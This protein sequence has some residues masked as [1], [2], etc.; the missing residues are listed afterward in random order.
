MLATLRQRDFALLWLAGLISVAGDFALIVALPLHV[1]QM[2]GS[3]IATAGTL[4][5]SMLPHVL[6]G[7]VAGVFV[8]RWDRKRT[9]VVVDVARA[10][11]LLPLLL[12]PERLEMVYAI[13]AVQGTI[14]LFFRPAEGALLPRLVGEERLV[15]ANA[16]NALNDNL[17][18]L[19]G[20][21]LGALLYARAGIGGVVL[22][23]AATYV[24]SALLIGLI[25]GNAR[26]EPVTDAIDGISPWRRV[27]G[28]WRS[29]LGIVGRNQALRV[30]FAAAAMAGVA[31]GVFLTL[32]LS[33]LVLDV[34]GGTPAQVGW[35]GSA[36]AVGGLI[37]GVVVA[38]FGGRLATRWL[39]GGGMVGIGLADLGTANARLFAGPGLPAVSVAMGWSTLAGLPVVAA[40][41]GRQ[42]LVQTQAADAYR[43]RVFGALGAIQGGAM[44]LGFAV[45]GVLGGAWG[46]VPTLSA[47]AMVRVLGGLLALWL[48]PRRPSPP[49]PSPG[50]T[51]KGGQF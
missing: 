8:D 41:T 40:S 23:D 15:S 51:F 20:P 46:L 45:G 31:E 1:Y 16:L 2:T 27:F 18:M 48:L 3:T 12:A 38:R 5:A 30:L 28:E 37:A 21:A 6:A 11:A 13:A 47:A 35:L 26:P 17:G 25:R 24:V 50:S 33:P 34:L 43:G 39:L 4:A 10:V 19:A 9:M 32:S 22:A 14:G 42:T 29:G 36:Q 49:T 7:S 44:L